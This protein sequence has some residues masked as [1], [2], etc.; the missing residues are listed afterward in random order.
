[1]IHKEFSI[2]LDTAGEASLSE[3]T[4]VEPAEFRETPQADAGAGSRPVPWR[5]GLAIALLFACWGLRTSGGY[6]VIETDAARHAMNGVFLRDLIFQGA[7]ARPIS[8][9]HTYYAQ[10]P[11]LSMPYHPPMFPL[12]EAGFY[13]IFGVHV[14]AARLAVAFSLATAALGL[15]LLVWRTHGSTLLAAV[16]TIT[17][18][19]LPEALWV[20]SDVMLEFPALAFAIWAIYCLHSVQ[21]RFPI[22]RALAFAL[23]A[24]AAVWTKQLTVFLG[25]A[26]ALYLLLAGRWRLCFKSA[27]WVA[28]GVFCAMVAALAS[29]SSSVHGAGVN[30]AIPAAPIPMYLA[31][32]RLVVRNAIFYAQHYQT[33]TGPAG[34]IL[35]AALAAALVLG[36]YRRKQEALYFSWAVTSLGVLFLLRP[37]A[38]RYLFFTYPALIV[39]GYVGLTRIVERFT[40]G[41][42]PAIAAALVV[43]ALAAVQ[44]P[45]RTAYLHGP[46]E[47]ARV[48]APAGARRILYC[49]GTDG[50][51]ILNYRVNRAGL[52]TTI[53]TGDK[54]PAATFAPGRLEQFA[55][56]YGVQY[57][58][59]ETASGWQGPWTPLI[60]EPPPDMVLERRIPMSSSTE[61]WN[62]DLRIYRFTNPSPEPKN[63]LAMRMFMIGGTMDFELGR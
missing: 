17:F 47:A 7:I 22:R 28:T 4:V 59:L 5:W 30:Q 51:F 26:P 14:L 35:M 61:R 63:D 42:R 46:D 54:L 15:F 16:S 56:D 60:A 37:Y 52:D 6:N 45:Y 58:V 3:P 33:V 12:I 8:F 31:Y 43:A 41:Q 62:G 36:L 2:P 32:Y 25:A 38:T 13:T 27:I 50:N 55:H 23:L 49:G 21:E 44:F 48:L 19:C 57:I 11:A 1:M 34:L 53:I 20:G 9:A 29:L 18:L 39:L 40:G 10:L 24:G